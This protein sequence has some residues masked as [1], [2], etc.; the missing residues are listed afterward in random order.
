MW[1][2]L[3]LSIACIMFGWRLIEFSLDWDSQKGLDVVD[4]STV[5]FPRSFPLIKSVIQ[6]AKKIL[7]GFV[8]T[9]IVHYAV[10]IMTEK[11]TANSKLA[12][13]ICAKFDM[14]ATGCWIRGWL[15]A[16]FAIYWWRWSKTWGISWQFSWLHCERSKCEQILQESFW[17]P[18]WHF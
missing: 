6:A 3:F 18:A 12:Q 5:L 10:K 17:K 16:H 14:K 7:P 1:P 2:P 4:E 13:G 15:I 11:P 8:H 9:L